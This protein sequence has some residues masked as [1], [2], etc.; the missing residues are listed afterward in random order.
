[1]TIG[2]SRAPAGGIP[3][4][5]VHKRSAAV[6]YAVLV[7]GNGATRV[8]SFFT[9]VAVA[10]AVSPEAFGEYSLFVA[11]FVAVSTAT[12]FIDWTYVRFASVEGPAESPPYLRAGL[13]MKIGLLVAVAAVAYPLAWLLSHHVFGR[14][15]FTDAV[16]AALVTGFGL[17]FVSLLAAVEQARERFWRVT[18]LTTVFYALV[19]AATAAWWAASG[20][21]T[22]RAVYWIYGFTAGLLALAAAARLLAVTRPLRLERPVLA[23]MGS[24]SR[25]LAA[26]NV[27]DVIGQ[28]LDLI[29]LAG[30]ATLGDVGQYGA[31]LRIVGVASLLTGVLPTLLMAR[32]SRTRNSVELLRA[33]LRA[34]VRLLLAVVPV[35]GVVWL[36]AP[37]LVD[38]FLGEEYSEA[39]SLTRI[40]LLGIG[41]SAVYAPLAQLFLADDDPR[42]ATYFSLLRLATLVALLVVLIPAIGT[43]GAAWA[44]VGSEFAA[45]LYTLLALVPRMK[46]IRGDPP[47]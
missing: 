4:A 21:L 29:L 15:G 47:E 45:A 40:M 24:F 18:L 42:R 11:L 27:T 8:F 10:R 5:N 14:P 46:T 16:A 17:T 9:A 28:R 35:L 19:L 7:V 39:A 37:T 13:A 6:D 36:L 33:Y 32:A 44:F 2:A 26:S 25:W 3:T 1:M 34:V 23:R 31:A 38:L 41:L 22:P 20:S 43:S 30:Y 12:A